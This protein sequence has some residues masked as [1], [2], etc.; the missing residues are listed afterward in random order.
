MPATYYVTRE[1][2]HFFRSCLM[3]ALLLL[4]SVHLQ[5]YSIPALQMVE[6]QNL[7]LAVAVKKVSAPRMQ[8]QA[9]NFPAQHYR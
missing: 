8:R 9:N 2:T 3:V 1:T 5:A 7:N 4:S 6:G